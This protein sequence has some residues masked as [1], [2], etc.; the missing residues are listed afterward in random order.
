[1]KKIIIAAILATMSASATADQVINSDM[2]KL[3]VFSSMETF[4]I[5]NESI[6]PEYRN[7]SGIV[8]IKT[9]SELLAKVDQGIVVRL[10]QGVQCE[11]I[12]AEFTSNEYT[13][14]F[15]NM[16]KDNSE[17]RQR[18]AEK[19]IGLLTTYTFSKCKELTA[20]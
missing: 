13:P 3:D 8:A 19:L 12:A 14:R 10:D 16:L 1:M 15:T 6:K 18:N 2:V 11:Y 4:L 9:A 17:I 5:L 20:G 7:K